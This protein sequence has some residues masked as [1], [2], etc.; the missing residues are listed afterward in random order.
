MARMDVQTG[1]QPN[2]LVRVSTRPQKRHAKNSADAPITQQPSTPGFAY[3]DITKEELDKLGARRQAIGGVLVTQVE[4]GSPA[5]AAGITVGDIITEAAGTPLQGAKQL[6][7]ILETQDT[8]RG[9]LLLIER[10]DRRTFAI[11]KP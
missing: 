8:D 5:D 6:G 11:L 1:E 4:S 9:I 3:Q 2:P 10:G 7:K